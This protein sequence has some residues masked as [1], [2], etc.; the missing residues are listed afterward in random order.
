MDYPDLIHVGLMTSQGSLQVEE[1]SRRVRVR[2]MLCEEKL[3]PLLLA[4]KMGRGP[5]VRERGWPPETKQ[6]KKTDSLLEPLK[7]TSP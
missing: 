7:G 2:M 3:N 6:N 4:L 1:E 5:A